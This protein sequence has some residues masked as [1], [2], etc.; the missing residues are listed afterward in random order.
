[1]EM[2]KQKEDTPRNYVFEQAFFNWRVSEWII[3]EL[4]K[5]HEDFMAKVNEW[6]PSVKGCKLVSASSNK[7]DR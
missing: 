6:F 3:E 2:T 7:H 1:M 4:R 5:P